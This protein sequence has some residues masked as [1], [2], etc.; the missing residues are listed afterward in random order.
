M[1]KLT[2]YERVMGYTMAWIDTA[3][4]SHPLTSGLIGG[5]AIGLVIL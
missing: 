2:M 3:I 1:K 5:L 4:E